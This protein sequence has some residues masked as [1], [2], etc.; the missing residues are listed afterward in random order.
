MQF[1]AFLS[2]MILN[3]VVLYAPASL[4]T[5]NCH[6]RVALGTIA[7]PFFYEKEGQQVGIVVDLFALLSSDMDCHFKLV[8]LP[9]SRVEREGLAGRVEVGISLALPISGNRP[10]DLSR[11]VRGAKDK[12]NAGLEEMPAHLITRQPFLIVRN[13]FIGRL[14]EGI[15]LASEQDYARWRFGAVH[16]P[17]ATAEFWKQIYGLPVPPKGFARPIQGLKSVASGRI[18]LYLAAEFSLSEY[19]AL[20]VKPDLVMVHEETPLEFRIGV[21]TKILQERAY[22]LI[23]ELEK[24]LQALSDSGAIKSIVENHSKLEYFLWPE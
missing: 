4:G 20:N 22:P 1:R 7:P 21:Y 24:K 15:R 10:E 5:E 17:Q 18:D 6:L 19:E 12:N 3:S 11:Y 16:L 23:L 13:G 9:Y 14:G 2:L 8:L